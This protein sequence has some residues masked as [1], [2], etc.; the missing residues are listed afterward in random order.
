MAL[1][2]RDGSFDTTPSSDEELHVGDVLITVGTDDEL[3]RMGE[4]FAPTAAPRAAGGTADA[5]SPGAG[6]VVR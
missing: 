3:Q 2:K 5:A 1:R 6:A 4:L